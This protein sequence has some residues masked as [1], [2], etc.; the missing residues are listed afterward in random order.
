M[1]TLEELSAACRK[2]TWHDDAQVFHDIIGSTLAV[3]GLMQVEL[4]AFLKVT[5]PTV[6]RW[7]NR[8]QT[9]PPRLRVALVR[10][11]GR[12]V[13][14]ALERRCLRCGQKPAGLPPVSS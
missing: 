14:Y 12:R 11:I 2:Y 1:W 5:P 7:V 6:S 8:Q 10:D 3:L 13:K 9:P 4:A